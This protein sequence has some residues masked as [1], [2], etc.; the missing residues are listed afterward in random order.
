MQLQEKI[1]ILE[2]DLQAQNEK[3]PEHV[4]GMHADSN[5]SELAI[6]M[7]EHN[8]NFETLKEKLVEL[9]ILAAS[10][11]ELVC[12]MQSKEESIIE[13]EK[14]LEQR[15]QDL[16]SFQSTDDMVDDLK[17]RLEEKDKELS[18]LCETTKN[19]SDL[20]DIEE[21]QR[22]VQAKDVELSELQGELQNASNLLQEREKSI[23][24]LKTSVNDLSGKKD[25]QNQSDSGFVSGEA[26]ERT[27]REELAST[28]KELAEMCIKYVVF[29]ILMY[30]M[31]NTGEISQ[32]FCRTE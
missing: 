22:L 5:H 9:E 17:R 2:S 21:M 32:G 11:K 14:L 26:S 6:L 19:T 12:E 15:S 30:G 16:K 13:L 28:R 8:L 10:K 24:E 23:E 7:E 27:L 31:S 29:T 18:D 1:S 20:N 4:E 3:I 25:L